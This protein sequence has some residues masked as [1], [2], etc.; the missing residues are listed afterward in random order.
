MPE[1]EDYAPPKAVMSRHNLSTGKYE[2]VDTATGKPALTK[3]GARMDGGGHDV[4]DTTVRQVE[5]YIQ[6][7]LDKYWAKVEAQESNN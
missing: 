3:T 5:R 1:N 2:V 6:P 4:E 7:G